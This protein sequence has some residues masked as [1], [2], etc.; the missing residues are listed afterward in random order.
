[1]PPEEVQSEPAAAVDSSKVAIFSE[2]LSG[3]IRSWNRAAELMFAYRAEEVIGRAGTL[4]LP[5]ERMAEEVTLRERVERRETIEHFET[6]R[7]HKSGARIEVSLALSPI[8]DDASRVT[9]VSVF[10]R[11]LSNEQRREDLVRSILAALPE[12]LIVTDEH[13]LIRRFNA[14]AERMFGYTLAEVF[15]TNVAALVSP[16]SRGERGGYIAGD[17]RGSGQHLSGTAGT[18]IGRRKGGDAFP[19]E[20]VV[21]EL[22]APQ[23]RSVS[24]IRDLTARQ[25]REHRINQLEEEL[26]HVSRVAELGQML[27][28]LAHEISQPLVAMANY[29]DAALQLLD[30]GEIHQVRAVLGRIA[31]EAERAN[32]IVL[33]LRGLVRNSPIEKRPEDLAVCIEEASAVALIGVGEDIRLEVAVADDAAV[34]L[35]D[36]IQIQQVLINLIRNAAEAMGKSSRRVLSIATARIGEMIEIR[37]ADTGPGLAEAVRARL[38]EP[39]VTTKPNGLGIGLSVCRSIIEAHGGEFS[40][41]DTPGSGTVFRLTVRHPGASLSE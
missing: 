39:F 26:V 1:M 5:A 21:G 10:A 19:I 34:A 7:L 4:M 14:A 13:G 27:S 22:A 3:V 16:P 24:L 2:D 32:T 23:H 38:F 40:A 35:I 37:V 17:L 25:A 33:R 15:G 6:E 41:A 31:R 30:T 18:A 20:F 8:V 36:R 11:A 29:R 9:G 12:A 28:A